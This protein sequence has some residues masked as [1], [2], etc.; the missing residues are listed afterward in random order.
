MKFSSDMLDDEDFPQL[1]IHHDFG[2]PRQAMMSITKILSAQEIN[3]EDYDVSLSLF[4]AGADGNLRMNRKDLENNAPINVDI[5]TAGN[6]DMIASEFG[7]LSTIV[8]DTNGKLH[9]SVNVWWD[10]TFFPCQEKGQ[11]FEVDDLV[12]QGTVSY[13]SD[14]EEILLLKPKRDKRHEISRYKA[15]MVMDGSKA[16]I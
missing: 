16:V 11:I 15:R 4:D 6:G 7:S 13:L 1:L 3:H 2:K 14:E 8:K 12:Q 9:H 10:E 5:I